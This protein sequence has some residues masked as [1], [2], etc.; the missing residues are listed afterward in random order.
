MAAV[1]ALRNF[2]LDYV[3]N[4]RDL[5]RTMVPVSITTAAVLLVA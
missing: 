3:N 2:T 4:P 1:Q 5:S